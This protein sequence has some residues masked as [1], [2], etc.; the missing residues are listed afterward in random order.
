MLRTGLFTFTIVMIAAFALMAPAQLPFPGTLPGTSIGGSLS[1]GYETSGVVWH[2]RHQRLF[3]VDD[4]GKVTSLLPDGSDVQSITLAGDLEGICVADPD[5]SFVYVADEGA[6]TIIEL[7]LSTGLPTRTF[8]LGGL[9]TPPTNTGIEALTFVNVAT[10]PEGG[11]FLAGLQSN[12]RVYVFELSI[13]TSAVLETVN[14]VGVLNPAP[15]R[16]DISGLDYVPET[17]TIF[18]TYSCYGSCSE[19]R[20]FD[21]AGNSV[22]FWTLPGADQEGIAHRGCQLFIAQDTLAP[23]NKLLRYEAFPAAPCITLE[24]DVPAISR[25]LGGTQV[26]SLDF[27]SAGA[28][29]AYAVLGT[30][31]GTSPGFDVAGFHVPLQPDFYFD[32]TLHSPASVPLFPP[33]G[34]LD[35]NGTALVSFILPLGLPPIV[36]G[37]ILYHAAFLV[38]TSPSLVAASNAA[39]LTITP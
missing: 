1:F 27:G 5:S 22:G 13:K 18:A 36:D 20:A 32:L 4:G 14:Q 10:H 28:N 2:T 17:L 35:A 16:S 34:F 3:I 6:G 24:V 7:D 12:G 11:F 19:I 23:V 9:F 8:F 25:L 21:I 26:L 38:D 29:L 30:V 31:S 39:P 37:A 33:R 15:G